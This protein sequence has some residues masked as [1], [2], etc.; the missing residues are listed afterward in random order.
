MLE[1]HPNRA[2]RQ[3]MSAIYSANGYMQQSSP[4][5]L[6]TQLKSIAS[7]TTGHE[8]HELSKQGMSPEDLEAKID[9]IMYLE[10]ETLRL[11]GIMLQAFIP[12]SAGKLLDMLGVRP[13]R[14]GWDWCVVGKDDAFGDPLIDLGKGKEGV[15]LFPALASDF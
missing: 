10:A 6:A 1:L 4:W 7:D 13:D 3:I 2:L 9:R 8:M 12:D 15:Q 11:V 14:R 5:T